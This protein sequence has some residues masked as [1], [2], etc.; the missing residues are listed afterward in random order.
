MSSDFSGSSF[1]RGS[2]ISHSHIIN[3]DDVKKYLNNCSIPASAEDVEIKENLRHDIIY[4]NVNTIEFIVTVDGENTTIPVKK[5][6]PS[7]LI[8]FFQ[9][10][11]L[12]LKSLDLDEMEKKPFVSPSDIG[13]LKKI[14]REKFVL[15]TKNV[16]L[17]KAE[18]F[19]T[20]V[21][22]TIQDFF[23][24][25]HSGKSSLL[26]T[27]HWFIFET[28]KSAAKK[29]YPL[30][31]CPHCGTKNIILEKDKISLPDFSWECTHP[32]CKKEIL[33]TDIFRLFEKIDNDAGAEGII[34]YL[35][36]TTETFLIIHTIKSLL[37][38][39]NGLV[40]R[41]LF[42]KDGPLSFGGETA[43]M[44]QPMQTLISHLNKENRI[45]LVGVE[46]S[47]P[48]A[49]H[50]KEIKDKLNPG[51]VYLLNNDYIYSYIKMRDSSEKQYGSTSYYSGKFFYKTHDERIYVL[52]IPVEDHKRYYNVPELND[53]PNI[54][55]VLMNIDKLKCDIYENALI[56]VA[57]ANKL[58]SLSNHPSSEILERFAKKTIG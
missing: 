7:S 50:A 52:T 58:I 28:Y 20:S 26:T 2:R 15:P 45:N 54:Q 27:V 5:S 3:D 14:E 42:V 35:K 24:K 8:T 47:G 18:D 25:T 11:S 9:F 56:P 57:L 36:N 46:N 19:K 23:R 49:D 48:F 38:I 17:N 41:F 32:K 44:H 43:N 34:T 39:E 1:E 4:P 10:G 30:S 12:L 13:K 53:L 16:S 6:F 29:S 51:Q 22:K 37:E 55:E 40:N 33:I 31:K 21:R